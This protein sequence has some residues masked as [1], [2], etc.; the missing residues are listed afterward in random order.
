MELEQFLQTVWEHQP[1]GFGFIG[2]KK[3][4][5]WKFMDVATAK[6]SKLKLTNKT[7]LYFT[8]NTFSET[9][10]QKHLVC[11]SKWLYAD[12]DEVNPETIKWEPSLWWE[13]SPGRY[14]GLWLLDRL[15]TSERHSLMNQKLTYLTNADR[16]GWGASKVLRVPGSISTKHTRYSIMPAEGSMRVYNAKDM[17]VVLR[18]IPTAVVQS[19]KINF[20]E[21]EKAQLLVKRVPAKTRALLRRR[22]VRDRSEHVY[23]VVAELNEAGFTA[24]EALTLMLTAPVAQEK[25]GARIK[26]E[27]SRV[28]AK[29]DWSEPSRTQ[30]TKKKTKAKPRVIATHSLYKFMGQEFTPPRWIVKGIWGEGSKGFIAGDPKTYKS[31]IAVDLAVSVASGKRF[32]GHFPVMKDA[33]G[34]VLYVDE[35][36]QSNLTQSRFFQVLQSKGLIKDGYVP[37]PIIKQVHIA[38]KEGFRLTAPDAVAW[39]EKYV[40]D[41]RI[42]MV[43]LDPLYYVAQGVPESGEEMMNLLV[44]LDKLCTGLGVALIIVHHFKKQSQENPAAPDDFQRM[45]GT[46]GMGRWFESILMVTRQRE[47][48]VRVHTEHRM[49]R[50]FGF[51]LDFE[52]SGVTDNSYLPQ[53]MVREDL[54]RDQKTLIDDMIRENPSLT[55]AE[56]AR[57]LGMGAKTGRRNLEKWGFGFKAAEGKK[58]PVLLPRRRAA[59]ADGVR[60]K[61]EGKGGE[62]R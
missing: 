9:R 33:R 42:K 5:G 15:I 23:L 32:L 40:R 50:G 37:D 61:N 30:K 8:P 20:E 38:S 62:S 11:S 6:A 52:V 45:S 17:W 22:R 48:G 2:W 12:L 36:N 47:G 14:Q 10:R 26:E 28:I 24:S 44:E 41:H 58:S 29:R 19:G 39:L 13:T 60:G 49:A 18:D 16:G 27:L 4:D 59:S 35:E 51:D 25:Y 21:T 56:A 55:V 7:D 34:P 53:V 1:S 3:A 46:G 43:I 54:D 31:T 57:A